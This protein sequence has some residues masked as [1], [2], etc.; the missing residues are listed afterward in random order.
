MIEP[1]QGSTP[2][3][4]SFS[5]SWERSS[6]SM[7]HETIASSD[8]EVSFRYLLPRLTPLEM[9]TSIVRLIKTAHG[10]PEGIQTP[11]EFHNSQVRLTYHRSSRSRRSSELVCSTSITLLN[12]VNFTFQFYWPKPIPFG[13]TGGYYSSKSYG[14]SERQ[15]L[16]PHVNKV[17]SFEVSFSREHNTVIWPILVFRRL[18]D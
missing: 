3:R 18:R 14:Q 12:K 16:F 2:I 9:L 6:S 15:S 8:F 4:P 1:N 11:R 17:N 13:R 5:H 10:L 7:V